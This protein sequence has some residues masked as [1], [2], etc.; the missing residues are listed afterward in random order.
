V[1]SSHLKSNQRLLQ[2]LNATRGCPVA[3][4]HPRHYLH[5]IWKQDVLRAA[6]EIVDAIP[7]G[8]TFILLDENQFGYEFGPQRRVVRYPEA[9]EWYWKTPPDAETAIQ[10][11]HKL[12]QEGATFMVVGWPAFIWLGMRPRLKAY[13]LSNCRCI[14]QT[15]RVL[16]FEL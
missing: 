7:R 11:L 16:V 13:L 10:E 4:V 1:E 2:E 14:L 15:E 6:L 9:E 3:L 8:G 5:V 12:N